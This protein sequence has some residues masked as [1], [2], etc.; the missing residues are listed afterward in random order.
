[1]KRLMLYDSNH[2]TFWK[3]QNYGDSLKTKSVV[4]RVE[5]DAERNFGAVK[6]LC[7]IL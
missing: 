7:E 4:A 5:K 3:K 2:M 1:M 6:L